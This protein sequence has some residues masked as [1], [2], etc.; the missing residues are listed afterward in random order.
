VDHPVSNPANTPDALQDELRRLRCELASRS[1]ELVRAKAAILL[2]QATLDATNDGV[3]AFQLGDAVPRFNNA[4][5]RMWGLPKDMLSG[6]ER[7]HLVA[8]LA[9]Q[10]KTPAELLGQAN[11]YDPDAEDFD[12]VELKD[13]RIFERHAKPQRVNGKSVGRVVNYRDVTLRAHF[14]H[15]LMFNHVVVENC[16]P[17]LWV[18]RSSARVVYA[19][20]AACENLGYCADALVGMAVTTFD[21]AFTA[22]RVAPM[23][24]EVRRTGKAVNFKTCFIR[25][26]GTS[27]NASASAFLAEDGDQALYI[28]SYTETPGK[29]V[30]PPTTRGR[31]PAAAGL[32]CRRALV[33]DDSDSARTV[34]GAMLQDMTF[35]VTEADCG[36]SA[37]EAVRAAAERGEAFDI[38]YLDW[39]MPGM[40]GM[41]TARRLKALDPDHGPHIVMATADSRSE[42][43]KQAGA[44]GLDDVLSKPI[45]ATRLFDTTMAALGSWWSGQQEAATACT[46]KDRM[47]PVKGARL[48]LV[49]DNDINQR[50]ATDILESAGFVVEVADNGKIGLEMVRNA[51]YDLV[52]MDMQ[53]PVMDGLAATAEIRK[54]GIYAGLPIVALTA[55]VTQDDRNR[56]LSAGMDDFLT[57]PIDPQGLCTVLLKWIKPQCINALDGRAER[58]T[59]H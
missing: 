19:N 23:E 13:G 25:K 41:E 11:D 28:V 14:E 43:L 54:L 50:V 59:H 51:R 8:L 52:L 24:E 4:F 37:V 34:L 33:V 58:V 47:A 15:K 55:N 20:S 40:D 9:A 53:M 49:E 29:G 46:E 6:L 1:E 7:E 48:L 57:K 42:A 10:V 2:L 45:D 39:R 44:V 36:A 5:V 22:E 31:H 12:I 3:V 26:N 27:C 35:D 18:D 16:G 32:R 30:R 21:P 56:C 38:V 17:M